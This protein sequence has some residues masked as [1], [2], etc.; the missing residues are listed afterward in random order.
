[1]GNYVTDNP[2]NLGKSVTADSWAV[3]A[4]QIQLASAEL[5]SPSIDAA[6]TVAE[7]SA[8]NNFTDLALASMA[9][10][11]LAGTVA[12]GDRAGL[13]RVAT[14]GRTKLTGDSKSPRNSSDGP[15]TRTA[16]GLRDVPELIREFGKLR[17]AGLL[18][19][20]EFIEQKRRL[21]SPNPSPG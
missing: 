20:E 1:V 16:A 7:G 17:D 14:H 5:S 12:P 13:V 11:A 18:T 6:P 10:R 8:G 4:P 19:D 9:G 21:L 2:S 3:A 15:E